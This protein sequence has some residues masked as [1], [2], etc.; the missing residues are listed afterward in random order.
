MHRLDPYVEPV[1]RVGAR[2]IGRQVKWE[3]ASFI[4][5]LLFMLLAIFV[6]FVRS[7]FVTLM[8]VGVAYIYLV[9]REHNA[10]TYKMLFLATFVTAVTDIIWLLMY[11]ANWLGGTTIADGAENNVHRFAVFISFI[12]LLAKLPICIIFWRTSIALS[13]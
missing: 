11:G 6:S 3:N 7:D 1:D 2:L 12:T 8:V 5:I 13:N 9:K 10:V 4:T